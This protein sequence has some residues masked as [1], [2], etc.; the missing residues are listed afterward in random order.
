MQRLLLIFTNS[1][2][3]TFTSYG[4]TLYLSTYLKGELRFIRFKF[5]ASILA[6][7][8]ENMQLLLLI[9]T[10]SYSTTF[11][12]YEWSLYFSLYV[13]GELRYIR[14]K[15][16]A[17]ILAAT[18]EY[19]QLLLL[20]PTNS[21]STTFT[22]YGWTLYLSKYLKGELRFIR[23]KFLA[24]ILAAILENMQL[25]LLIFTYS[26]ST[27]FTSYEWTLYF[28]L[29]VEGELRYIRFKFSAAILAATL[30]KYATVVVDSYIFI[31]Y[32]LHFI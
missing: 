8:L 17:A 28:S 11:T 18:I 22:S 6:A 12:S 32:D 24:A 15:F 29:Y 19:M 20:I 23:F 14:F 4:W 27:T 5:L 25:L 13:E 3:T 30:E 9:F 10:Y 1:Y 16:S 26:Y 2:S 31:L 21:Y 7:I